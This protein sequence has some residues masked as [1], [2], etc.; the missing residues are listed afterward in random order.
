MRARILLVSVLLA[1]FFTTS[2]KLDRWPFL[3]GSS[4][5]PVPAEVLSSVRGCL[6]AIDLF[7]VDGDVEKL[8]QTLDVVGHGLDPW[9]QTSRDQRNLTALAFRAT[10]PDAHFTLEEIARANGAYTA[11]LAAS[12]IAGQLP[13]WLHPWNGS[14]LATDTL[15]LTLD[16]TGSIVRTDTLPFTELFA[17]SLPDTGIPFR[18]AAPAHLIGAQLTLTQ[19][20]R[21][22]RYL[23]V[24]G[25]AVVAPE[26]GSL[27]VE[28]EGHLFIY[29]HARVRWH[30]LAA[31]ESIVIEPGD[32]LYLPDGYA[33]L[34]MT[35][36]DPAELF[37]T[38]TVSRNASGGT[39]PDGGRVAPPSLA[40][41]LADTSTPTP[42]W[43]G[44]IDSVAQDPEGIPMGM[45]TLA[46]TWV[47][48]PSDSSFGM[49]AGLEAATTFEPW[50]DPE[51]P[52]TP[53]VIDGA[54][55][56][57]LVLVIRAVSM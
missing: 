24:D 7:I 11:K 15:S 29:D 9:P 51:P 33:V 23:A 49:L 55:R 1:V 45:A 37:Y 8:W 42:T 12:G 6:A 39:E 38:G 21:G 13:A 22:D 50:A 18:V 3:G 54:D 10:Y 47:V 57:R 34:A 4:V 25:P 44:S 26:T 41:M 17:L 28:G 30:E 5:E 32:L 16:E 27:R 19:S 52:G 43:F 53:P 48:A 14:A 36:A 56:A 35:T 31:A 20:T 2:T 46:P 40:A